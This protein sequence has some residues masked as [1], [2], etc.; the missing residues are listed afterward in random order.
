SQLSDGTQIRIRLS[1]TVYDLVTVDV[2]LDAAVPVWRRDTLLQH[3]FDER[4]IEPQHVAR[5]TRCVDEI[6]VVE[7]RGIRLLFCNRNRSTLAYGNVEIACDEFEL[8]RLKI[9]QYLFRVFNGNRH[10][11]CHKR[12]EIAIH[13]LGFGA[14]V[15]VRPDSL[16]RTV[17]RVKNGLPYPVRGG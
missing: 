11:I 5:T 17:G 13:E 9:A 6:V 8:P 10:P 12:A 7:C 2:D 15:Q 14:F 4:R 16:D 1:I 3:R